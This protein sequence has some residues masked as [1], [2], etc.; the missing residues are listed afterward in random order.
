MALLSPS[1]AALRSGEL[2]VLRATGEAGSPSA[3]FFSA[4]SRGGAFGATAA[5]GE[6][7]A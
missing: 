1:L 4:G 3:L 2:I 6:A 7:G 5:A